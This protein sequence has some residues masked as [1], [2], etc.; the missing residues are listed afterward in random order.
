MPDVASI[1]AALTGLKTAADIAKTMI[2]M[3]SHAETQGK[4]IELQS[5]ILA[6]QSSALDAQAAQSTLL[7]EIRNLKEQV[8]RVKD[9]ETQ[10]KRY[11]LHE[12]ETTK[13]VFVY[14][15]KQDVQPPEPMHQIC[16]NC[17]ENGQKSLLQQ[18]VRYPGI[19]YVLVCLNCGADVYQHG[20]WQPEHS[21]R[22]KPSRR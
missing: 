4:V 19:A 22:K 6:A 20:H 9:W 7:E 10:K 5:V 11:E 3:K 8:A 18:E 1:G 15:L 12:L 21:G 16:A 14:R 2:D 13:G 17:Y